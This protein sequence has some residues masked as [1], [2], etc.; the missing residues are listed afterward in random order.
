MGRRDKFMKKYIFYLLLTS[1]VILLALRPVEA[2]FDPSS[3]KTSPQGLSLPN[4]ND[5]QEIPFHPSRILVKFKKGVAPA[6]LSGTRIAAMVH[7][8]LNVAMVEIVSGETVPAV[9]AKW[10]QNPMVDYAEPDYK[11]KILDTT[12]NDPRW[13]EQWDMQKIQAPK[14][15]DTQTD[16]SDVVVGI[17]DTGIDFSH[18]DLQGNLWTDPQDGSHGYDCIS[19]QVGGADD[20][21]HGTHVAGTIGA[22]GHNGQGMAGINW[23]VKLMALKMLNKDGWGYA[24]DAIEC[25]ERVIELR[26]RGV[27]IRLTNNS[28][29]AAGYSQA[30]KDIMLQAEQ[31]GVL[32]I[33]AA[34]NYSLNTDRVPE[35]PAS[36]DNRGIVS[37]LSTDNQDGISWFS[38][39]GLASVDIAAPGDKT[40]ST[41]PNGSC[42]FCDPSGFRFLSGTS[43]A[44][45]HVVGV[46]AALLHRNPR[47][48]V[49]ELRDVLLHPDSYDPLSHPRAS[50]S[51]TGGRLNF[52]KSIAN[53]ILF[54]P[55]LNTFPSIQIAPF[56]IA[57]AGEA[58][59]MHAVV[60]DLDGDPLRTVIDRPNYYGL[61]SE[62][63]LQLVGVL[64]TI[65]PLESFSSQLDFKAPS[66]VQTIY[67]EYTASVADG[68]GGSAST[69]TGLTIVASPSPGKPPVATLSV[70]PVRIPPGGVAD[71]AFSLFDPEGENVVY[72]H[73]GAQSDHGTGISYDSEKI[74]RLKTIAMDPELHLVESNPAFVQVGDASDLP[75]AARLVVDRISGASPLRVTVSPAASVDPDG[76]IISYR[77]ACD[78]YWS[79]PTTLSQN[80]MCE[81]KKPGP[82]S[83]RMIVTDNAGN[84]DSTYA[85]LFV[86]PSPVME[87]GP[88]EA[89]WGLTAVPQSASFL[90]HWYPSPASDLAGYNVYRSGSKN[91]NHVKLNPTLLSKNFFLDSQLS[92]AQ[93]GY[94]YR[95]SAV[96]H[97][98]HESGQS[99]PANTLDGNP[100]LANVF[101]SPTG[102]DQNPCSLSQPCREIRKALTYAVPGATLFVADGS[103]KGFDM[104]AVKG[105]PKAPITIKAQGS[106]VI[107][108]R[109]NDRP[110]NK[111]NGVNQDTIY[112]KGSKNLVI[113]GLK[114]SQ[115]Y[116]AGIR[117]EASHNVTV[118][119]TVLANNRLGVYLSHAND[120][121]VENNRISGGLNGIYVESSGDRP[122]IRGNTMTDAQ[123]SAIH[124]A[125]RMQGDGV[126]DT[127]V[128]EDGIISG[129]IIEKNILYGNGSK[130]DAAIGCEG[131]QDAVI[132]NNLLYNNAA[133]GID[134]RKGNGA[135]GPKSV[136]I[137]HNTL[138]MSQGYGLLWRNSAGSNRAR[139]N[140]LLTR[141]SD[142]GGLLYGAA[143]DINH[144]DS[145]YNVI[146]KMSPNN[147]DKLQTLS[148]WQE[149]GKEP[150]SISA[151]P[152][153]LFANPNGNDYRLLD[154]SPAKDRGQTL[155]DVTEDL[156]PQR[157]PFGASSDIGAYEWVGP[158][159]SGGTSPLP[160]PGGGIIPGGS[161]SGALARAMTSQPLPGSSL[162]PL[163]LPDPALPPPS[164]QPPSLEDSGNP[165]SLSELR[166]YLN[167][168]DVD[169]QISDEPKEIFG[170]E[171]ISNPSL[172]PVSLSYE[173]GE[174]TITSSQRSLIT[175]FALTVYSDPSSRV[176]R[177]EITAAPQFL[178]A[179]MITQNFSIDRNRV[180]LQ[181]L[182]VTP[183]TYQLKVEAMDRSGRRSA[184]AWARV[185]VVTF[186]LGSIRV[187]PNPWRADQHASVSITF[188]G[189]TDPATIKIFTEAGH[190]VKTLQST[191]GQA[192]WDRTNDSG[193]RVASGLYLYLIT[194]PQGQKSRGKLA[195][196]R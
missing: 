196:I 4:P 24:S 29:G 154:N 14:A 177:W 44:T 119:N 176:E 172:E 90:L 35:F 158:T 190:H 80:V 77:F 121:R 194:N 156:V 141:S 64:E 184:A 118:K 166:A 160:P 188:D 180:R 161:T 83:I 98:G 49:H 157:R 159:G 87:P 21:G 191:S 140:I 19:N 113:E 144:A 18:P 46:A 128:A 61:E 2:V 134:I 89:P 137:Y 68:R 63:L 72:V 103:Y 78:N 96:D 95:V 47:L 42:R 164:D 45:P 106:N 27:N 167:E 102:S 111:A 139:N 110:A 11:V 3:T 9:I 130:G 183:G 84:S 185:S 1:F 145:D 33:V 34:G 10:K 54:A 15:W 109:T 163:P 30:E 146:Q 79:Y 12:P 182:G 142:R 43:M 75:P 112:I 136:N 100:I 97:A 150:H 99:D 94:W 133:M 62:Y 174:L 40:L 86:T 120:I 51:S 6:A 151:I 32:H 73:H 38:N 69:K 181:D 52:S 22:V 195:L 81:F 132:K 178:G 67:E 189:L 125:G 135:Q 101:V 193:D 91:G 107:I 93:Q 28:W 5:A 58:V 114:I 76:Q 168:G 70:A 59:Q 104:A 56:L 143:V 108:T 26:N 149:R 129:A 82:H 171:E 65:L 57:N 74:V 25:F 13:M 36:Y 127:E 124:L 138:S 92:S 105:T 37:V 88:P 192:T 116:R 60:Q 187:Y 53:P 147:G 7:P 50:A 31:A 175:Q 66:V 20:N 117:I 169:E 186:D 71:I 23:K 179:M 126:R 152:T 165:L 41:V 155:S 123:D 162:L 170:D 48:S 148:R 85:F 115:A 16:A 153:V 122:I 131:V 39:F 8:A 55:R 173:K 17:I